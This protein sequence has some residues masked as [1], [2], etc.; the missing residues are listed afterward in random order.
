MAQDLGLQRL[1][2]DGIDELIKTIK[3]MIIPQALEAKELFR[4]GQ[5]GRIPGGSHPGPEPHN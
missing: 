1:Q 2:E 5:Q 4:S 3:W